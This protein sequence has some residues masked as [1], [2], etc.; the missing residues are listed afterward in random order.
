MELE[1]N[2]KELLQLLS[3]YVREDKVKTRVMGMTSLGL[4]EMTRKKIEKPLWEQI[5]QE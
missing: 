3:S 1:E 2:R 5:K 4:V